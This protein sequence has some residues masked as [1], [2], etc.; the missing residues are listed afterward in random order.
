MSNY[1]ERCSGYTGGGA[2]PR[3][4]VAQCYYL[5]DGERIVYRGMRE[6]C[7]DHWERHDGPAE[8][9]LHKVPR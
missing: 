8:W 4:S 5:W 3:A 6:E 1:C 2:C 9:T 7:M